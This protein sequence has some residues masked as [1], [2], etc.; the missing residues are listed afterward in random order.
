[1]KKYLKES[2]NEIMNKISI[3]IMDQAERGYCP[4]ENFTEE[5]NILY[6]EEGG[7]KFE[8]GKIIKNGWNSEVCGETVE[9]EKI[10]A[11]NSQNTGW[12]FT[13]NYSE[14]SVAVTS[15]PS[16]YGSECSRELA[17]EI[18]ERLKTMI[19]DKFPGIKIKN[20]GRSDGPCQNVI[21][22]IESWI[23]ENWTAAL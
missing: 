10:Y 12:S 23:S 16:Y 2:E 17:N 3:D 21:D 14:Y 7:E 15:E 20:G 11:I 19:E 22:E 4:P 8:I 1:M 5:N 18:S 13:K 9:G 6:Y